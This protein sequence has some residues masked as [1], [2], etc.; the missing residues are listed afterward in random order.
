MYNTL[1]VPHIVSSMVN[2]N[3]HFLNRKFGVFYKVSGMNA[4]HFTTRKK[5]LKKKQNSRKVASHMKC[6]PSVATYYYFLSSPQTFCTNFQR[7]YQIFAVGPV[8]YQKLQFT[9]I[10]V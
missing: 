2:V 9:E 7:V 8:Q 4:T 1:N 10:K 3:L 5:T 6:I